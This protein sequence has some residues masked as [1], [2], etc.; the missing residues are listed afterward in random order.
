MLKPAI[1]YNDQL[2]KR[3]LECI[4][5][6]RFKF[7]FLGS[8][9]DYFINVSNNSGEMLQFV[10]LDGQGK[11]I[12]YFGA[13]MNRETDT[14]Y[15]LQMLNFNE[16]SFVFAKDFREFFVTLFEKYGAKKIVWSVVVGNPAEAL[17]DKGI[18]NHGGRVIG[19]FTRDTKLFDGQLYD[20]KYYE[21]LPENFVLRRK[22]A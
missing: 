10:S 5:Q 17:Y 15:D 11:V 13:R 1:L 14:A 6:D 18:T 7:Y 19:T 9:V 16:G 12:G 22:E 20:L 4:F 2:Q 8:T 3:F 21:V